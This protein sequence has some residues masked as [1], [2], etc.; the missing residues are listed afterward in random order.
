MSEKDTPDELTV[1]L[2]QLE[3]GRL[4]SPVPIGD[5]PEAIA[6]NDVLAAMTLQEALNARLAVQ[7][8]GP[9]VGTKIGCT[10]E[11]MQQYLG[12]DHPCSGAI[13]ESTVHA[14]QGTFDFDS[15][16]HVGVECE[17]AV[18]LSDAIAIRD[19]TYTLESI[20]P[21]VKSVHAAIEVVDDRYVDFENRIPDWR[22]WVADDLFGAGAVLGYPITDWQ[23]IDLA[24]VCG[25]M[26]I[27]GESV[28]AG[29]GRDIINGHPLEALVWLANEQSGLGREIPAGWVVMLGSVVQTKWLSA[30]DLVEVDLEGLGRAVAQF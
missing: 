18:T 22:T 29:F 15:F 5:L 30:G 12:M 23:S 13:F 10:T 11:V 19:E 17:I 25:E 2:N 8:L 28:G 9:I 1:A 27:N 4:Q 24:R 6:P 7:G 26:F 20:I 21:H 14:L 16:L 3:A